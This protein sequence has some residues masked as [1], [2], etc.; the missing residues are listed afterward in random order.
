M[1]FSILLKCESVHDPIIAAIGLS[2]FEGPSVFPIISQAPV[3]SVPPARIERPF[4]QPLHLFA[5]LNIP[6]AA[7]V[8]LEPSFINF[9]ELYPDLPRR[10]ALLQLFG[11]VEDDDNLWAR[12]CFW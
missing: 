7:A 1:P 8:K 3:A 2:D 4:D 12:G 10:N 11:P 6:E 5:H 9:R